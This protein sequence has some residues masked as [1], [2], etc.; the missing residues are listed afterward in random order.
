MDWIIKLVNVGKEFVL[1]HNQGT[2]LPVLDD[3]CDEFRPEEAICLCGPSGSGKTTILNMIGGRYRV[4][5][6]RILVHYNDRQFDMGSA[7]PA[8]LF[9]LLRHVIGFVGASLKPIPRVS[10]LDTVIE[11]MLA[12]KIDISKARKHGMKI[13]SKVNI[14]ENLWHLSPLTFSSGEQQRINIAR[15]FIAPFPV[16][17]LDEPYTHLGK[18]D[19]R[20]LADLMNQALNDG[21][22]IISSFQ[23]YPDEISIPFRCLEF[24]AAQPAEK[25]ADEIPVQDKTIYYPAAG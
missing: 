17:L 24:T 25:P 12:R 21:T 2:R 6:G 23:D 8:E 7:S 20:I 1:H 5:K 11:P 14:P 18:A 4:N 3:V 16:M 19:Q 22:C 13:L 10:T 15:G 9:Y